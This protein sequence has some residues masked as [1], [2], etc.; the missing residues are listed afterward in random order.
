MNS[1]PLWTTFKVF[2]SFLCASL[3]RTPV[4]SLIWAGRPFERARGRVAGKV[5]H[6]LGRIGGLSYFS[7]LP[8]NE[9]RRAAAAREEG[10]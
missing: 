4:Q 7:N 2:L 3:I 5:R 9:W 6:S 8:E 1:R 10:K